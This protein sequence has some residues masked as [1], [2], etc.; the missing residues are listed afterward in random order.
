MNESQ[1]INKIKSYGSLPRNSIAENL[2]IPVKEVYNLLQDIQ[3]IQEEFIETN[4]STH[5]QDKLETK[6]HYLHSTSK[7]LFNFICN[8]VIL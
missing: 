3:D 5:L 8:F 7:T 2:K 6:Y 1:L 4:V